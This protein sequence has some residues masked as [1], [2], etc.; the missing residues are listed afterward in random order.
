MPDKRLTDTNRRAASTSPAHARG[1]RGLWSVPLSRRPAV[2]ILVLA[3][4]VAGAAWTSAQADPGVS[5][6]DPVPFGA[7]ATAGPLRISVLEVITGTEATDL[8]TGAGNEAPREGIAYVAIR[9]GVANDGERP[10]TLDQN[11]FALTG[12]SAQVRRFVGAVA[13]DP[14]LDGV[15]APGERREGWVVLAAATDETSLLLVFDSL[16]LHGRWADR[17]FAL[18][19]EASVADAA[20][21][22]AEPDDT[23]TDPG[24]PAGIGEP[25]TTGQWQIELLEIAT[26]L[27]VFNL[28]DFRVQALGEG[29]AV[30][31]APWVALRVRV[32]NVQAGGEPAFLPATA[33]MLVNAEGNAVNDVITLTAPSPEASGYYYPGAAREG[34]VSLE[35][36]APYMATGLSLI[37]FLPWR[38][39]DDARYITY[40]EEYPDC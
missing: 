13:P 9:L 37:R 16:S 33:F 6:A 19:D 21:P 24:E 27:E 10:V 11:D 23:A 30:D 34:W 12:A 3:L 40:D 17:V 8:V 15:L 4:L 28:S 14:A 20:A 5:R 1:V 39:D 29:D 36:P 18:E 31:E 22:A 2:L 38:T 25:F 32:T 7:E 26:C 35:I